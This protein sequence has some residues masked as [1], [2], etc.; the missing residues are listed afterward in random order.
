MPLLS[1]LMPNKVGCAGEKIQVVRRFTSSEF[2]WLGRTAT[3]QIATNHGTIRPQEV[4]ETGG[5]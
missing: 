4:K 1:C 5:R 2:S 3:H